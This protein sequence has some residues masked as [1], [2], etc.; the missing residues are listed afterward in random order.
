MNTRKLFFGIFT[1]SL[2]MIASCTTEDSNLYESGVDK[3]KV[4]ISNKQSVDK[5]KV[6]ISNNQSVDKS[7]VRISNKQQN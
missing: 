5:S 3:S 1:C 6:R 2:L 7:K 4:R